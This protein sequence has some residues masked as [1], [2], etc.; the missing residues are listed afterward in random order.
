M[1]MLLLVFNE[2]EKKNTKVVANRFN[3]KYSYLE[4]GDNK[5]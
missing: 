3:S 1:Q 2:F 4:K 5:Y